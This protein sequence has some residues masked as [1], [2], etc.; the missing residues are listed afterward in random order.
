MSDE[1]GLTLLE[2]ELEEIIRAVKKDNEIVKSNEAEVAEY[3]FRRCKLAEAYIN[4]SP[5]DPDITK[6]Q[7]M[8]WKAYQDFIDE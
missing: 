6:K 7:L 5:C 8:A 2:S 1:Y 3:W 4:E